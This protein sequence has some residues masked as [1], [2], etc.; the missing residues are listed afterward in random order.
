M[1]A[2]IIISGRGTSLAW[3]WLQARTARFALLDDLP[4]E[5]HPR[6]RQLLE[7]PATGADW[8]MAALEKLATLRSGAAEFASSATAGMLDRST[9]TCAWVGD[10]RLGLQQDRLSRWIT[11]D[12]TVAAEARARG[13]PL[14]ANESVYERALTRAL[15]SLPSDPPDFARV[16]VSEE[17]A[18]LLC[19]SERHRYAASYDDLL[20]HFQDVEAH[21]V[22]LQAGRPCAR[23]SASAVLIQRERSP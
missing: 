8:P 2:A 23:S 4:P 3:I 12:H 11:S 1:K 21:G 18:V 13:I 15:G 17:L 5:L 20:S 10:V 6:A 19:T 16:A 9:L 22:P 7:P 14:P